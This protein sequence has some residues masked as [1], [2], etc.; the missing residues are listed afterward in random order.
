MTPAAIGPQRPWGPVYDDDA[1]VL[2]AP[3]I[4]TRNDDRSVDD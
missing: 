1:A 2:L 3:I 4:P